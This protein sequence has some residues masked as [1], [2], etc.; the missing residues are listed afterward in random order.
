M[1]KTLLI[2]S[3][4]MGGVFGSLTAQAASNVTLYGVI[5][6]SV[7]FTHN[8]G[9]SKNQNVIDMQSGFRNGS[10]F[11]IKGVEDLGNGYSVGFILEDGINSDDGTNAQSYTGGFSRESKLYVQ[12]DFGQIGFGRLGSLA[13]GAQSNSMLTG[14][15]LGTSYQNQGTW[16]SFARGNSRLNNAIAYVSPE[17]AGLKMSAMYSNGTKTDTDKWSDNNH[18]YGVGAQYAFGGFK[19]SLIFEAVDNKNSDK[20]TAYLVHLGL[21]YNFGSITPQFAYQYAWQDEQYKQHTFG[22]SAAAPV[23]GGTVKAGVKYLLLKSEID[24]T[25]EAL[26]E[27]KATSL[28]LSAAYEYPLSKRT[29]VW[30][31]ASWAHGD[32]L[33]SSDK[34]KKNGAL[35]KDAGYKNFYNY[36]GYVLSVGMT[37]NF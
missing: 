2:T 10:R 22:L 37:H 34:L 6:T 18:Y 23:A 25:K 19:N 12:G 33:F 31:F 20:E 21:G 36:D 17:F 4:I 26:G 28:S 16:T 32:K 3:M 8:G 30:S 15:A 13:G 11:G 14:W 24:G 35:Y 27:D 29:T 1:K 5:D 7:V 9:V